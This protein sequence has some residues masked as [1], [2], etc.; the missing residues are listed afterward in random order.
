LLPYP[1][2]NT[3]PRF[4]RKLLA[5]R[6]GDTGPRPRS[7]CLGSSRGCW[8]ARVLLQPGDE[9]AELC[10]A[11]CCLARSAHRRRRGKARINLGEPLVSPDVLAS[12][13][14]AIGE[15]AVR[16]LAHLEARW[17]FVA[18]RQPAAITL[19]RDESMSM[20]L[21]PSPSLARFRWQLRSGATAVEEH[22]ALVVVSSRA[23]VSL[24]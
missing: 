24:V 13:D 18:H 23:L 5:H 20:P 11:R 17:D 9:C 21:C 22:A 19:G 15:L 7:Y 2:E 12:C 1:G 6:G 14:D 10:L 3:E 16:K 4:S 8:R